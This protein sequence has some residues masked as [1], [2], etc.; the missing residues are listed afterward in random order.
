MASHFE[1]ERFSHGENSNC[2]VTVTP[3]M[4]KLKVHIRQ[5]YVNGNSEIR[6]GKSGI[7]LEIE[8]FYELVKLIPQVKT[9]TERY[10][11]EDTGIPSSPF[12]LDLP[13]VDLNTVFLPSPP[14]QEPIPF[15]LD[16]QLLVSQPKFPSSPPSTLP[17]VPPLIEPSL[18]KILSDIRFG[19]QSNP[20]E[21]NFVN[22][23]KRKMINDFDHKCSKLLGSV[24]LGLC[25]IVLNVNPRKRRESP[26][27]MWMTIPQRN[28]MG[29]GNDQA[30]LHEMPTRKQR[31][32]IK[33]PVESLWV[34]L[35]YRLSLKKRPK[36]RESMMLRR[37]VST[38]LLPW[39]Q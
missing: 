2:M 30:K 16:E 7:T 14:T 31:L 10:E 34:M 4:G 39:R 18:E 5:F 21:I 9:G 22:N 29:K 3:F 28:E 24:I 20:T 19:E 12:K 6:P 32:K 1:E 27:K 8:E 35:S 36:T 11:C 33:D 15:T 13:V 38:R 26:L 25:C 17:D 37:N 23:G